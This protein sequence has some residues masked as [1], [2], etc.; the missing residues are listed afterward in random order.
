MSTV[1]GS[2]LP[3][4]SFEHVPFNQK[5]REILVPPL[6]EQARKTWES[7]IISSPDKAREWLLAV[8][9]VSESA[10]VSGEGNTDSSVADRECMNNL[11]LDKIH[12]MIDH[13]SQSLPEIKAVATQAE[14]SLDHFRHSGKSRKDRV[15]FMDAF[16]E[17]FNKKS[18]KSLIRDPSAE[19]RG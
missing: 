5:D 18:L 16:R 11:D 6:D 14:V 10:Y 15:R 13:I 19:V 1:D 9:N 4:R 17:I 8:R 12:S 7:E 3:E 2:Q